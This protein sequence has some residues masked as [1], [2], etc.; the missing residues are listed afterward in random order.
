MELISQ[1]KLEKQFQWAKTIF[2]STKV[3]LIQTWKPF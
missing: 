3:K 2:T 1:K